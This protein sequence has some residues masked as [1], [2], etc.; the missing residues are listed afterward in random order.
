MTREESTG[1]AA[2]VRPALLAL[3]LLLVGGAGAAIA[4]KAQALGWFSASATFGTALG[5]VGLALYTYLLARH[6]D[7]SVGNAE[8]LTNLSIDQLEE[9]R[10]QGRLIEE[11]VRVANQQTLETAKARI[12]AISPLLTLVV[13]TSR[14]GL[15]QGSERTRL[16][17]A[18]EIAERDLDHATIEVALDVTIENVGASPAIVTLGDT[19][20]SVAFDRDTNPFVLVPGGGDHGPMTVRFYGR[21][22]TEQK[23]ISI[24]ITYVGSL[25]GE[26]FDRLQWNGIILPATARDGFATIRPI[27]VIVSSS[28]AQVVRSYPNLERPEEMAE[29]RA[30]FLEAPGREAPA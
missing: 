7:R 26:V 2:A 6:T 29:A 24:P 5:T 20:S 14:V 23:I 25:H 9:V 28:G 22:A 11:Q 27:P 19:S 12:D 17:E 18:T 3:A 4:A 10:K 30:R 15:V 16:H 21:K 1:R 13:A 8:R